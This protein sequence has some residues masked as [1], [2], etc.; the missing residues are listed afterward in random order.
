MILGVGI[1]LIEVTRFERALGRRG[2]ALLEML[3]S[4]FELGAWQKDRA[5]CRS[6]AAAFAVKEALFKAIGTGWA[7]GVSWHDVEVTNPCGRTSV[8]LSGE[9]GRVAAGLG[10]TR[11]HVST[12]AG[13]RLAAAAVVL[14]GDQD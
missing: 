6:P 8:R 7:G 3:F 12:A 2:D 11:V 4:P 10:V 5:P 9:A 1:D 13:R 14:E